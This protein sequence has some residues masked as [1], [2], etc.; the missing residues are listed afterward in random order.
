MK[1]LI[2]TSLLIVILAVASCQD[3]FTLDEN[4]SSQELNGNSNYRSEIEA[5][6]IALSQM[7][8]FYPEKVLPKSRSSELSCI[9]LSFN[10]V[11]RNSRGAQNEPDVFV[12]N[13]PNDSGFVVVPTYANAP[14]VLAVTECGNITSLDEIENPA[15]Q[16][17]MNQACL[18][19][20]TLAI[21][22]IPIDTN[23]LGFAKQ[24]E[25]YDTIQNIKIAPKIQ[26]LTW[27]QNPP[28]GLLFTNALADCSNVATAMI[29]A[30]FE[31]PKSITLTYDKSYRNLSLNWSEIKKHRHLHNG[32]AYGHMDCPATNDAHN[33]LSYLCKEIAFQSGSTSSGTPG[34]GLT[35]TPSS[36]AFEV[37]QRYLPDRTV[38]KVSDNSFAI[39]DIS[40]GIIYME[41][42]ISG[43][44]TGHSWVVDGANLLVI[45]KNTYYQG[46][47][48]LKPTLKN[49]ETISH[50]MLHI[51]WGWGGD[52]N[53]YFYYG[54]FNP[55]KYVSLD[56]NVL[57][58]SENTTYSSIQY[59]SIK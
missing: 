48:D 35:G 52:G 39:S 17:I 30:Y 24:W 53:G 14:E 28:E 31:S 9:P 5:I 47:F 7:Q 2:F 46:Q 6:E 19:A 54:A 40:N 25:E 11:H 55:T 21:N 1:K 50:L 57:A 4:I 41:G 38:K 3:N 22:P 42:V 18:Y 12:V 10:N 45:H 15:L 33:Q 37:I 26:F 49:Q 56:P 59:T 23:K 32:H 34:S 13:F 20:S 58:S 8:K 27:S 44:S 51:N 29:F 16:I 43:T 36:K